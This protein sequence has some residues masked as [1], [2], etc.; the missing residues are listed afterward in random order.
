MLTVVPPQLGCFNLTGI[1]PTS[2]S[3]QLV[4]REAQQKPQTNWRTHRPPFGGRCYI[5]GISESEARMLNPYNVKV[6]HKPHSALRSNLVH[7]KDLVPNLQRRK[8]AHQIPSS[9]CDRTCSG[10][11]GCLLGTRLK[12]HRSSVKEHDTN[13]CLAIHCMGRGHTFNWRGIPIL[14]CA[15]P[16]R[17]SEATEALHSGE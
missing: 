12:E 15:K 3:K 11:T 16:Q 14:G 4:H 13:S 5:Q 17:A 1:L 9:G 2:S 7:V 8:V 6:V 10:Q